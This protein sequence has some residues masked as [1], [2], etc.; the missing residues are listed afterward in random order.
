MSAVV[1]SSLETFLTALQSGDSD[2]VIQ[3]WLEQL[4]GNNNPP[5]LEWDLIQS[6]EPTWL[7]E[8][9]LIPIAY[10]HNHVIMAHPQANSDLQVHLSNLLQQPLVLYACSE[11]SL[12]KFWYYLHTADQSAS[13][14]SN[15]KPSEI[16]VSEIFKQL[17]FRAKQYRASDIHL[18]PQS[19]HSVLVR[20][21]IDGL[22]H[23]VETLQAT[24]FDFNTRLVSKIKVAADLDIA[25]TRI[26]QDGRITEIIADEP[27]DLR[28]ST[29]P[30][31]H[32]EKVVIRL[33]PHKN[34][35]QELRDLGLEGQ[36]L[37]T[38]YNWIKKPQGMVLITG[39]TGS[40]KTSTLYTTLSHILNA[41][42]N[43]VTIEDP[44]EYQL[45][46]A[47][48]VQVH[49]KV[50]LTFANGLRSIL[51]QDPDTILLGEIRDAE[52]AEIAYQAALTGHLV[53]STLHT[54][55]APSAIIRLMDIQVEPYLIASATLGVV[56][57]RLIR[58]VCKHCAQPY[59]PGQDLLRS[60]NLNPR[61]EYEFYH[62]M[63]CEAC[64]Q[65]GYYGREGIFEVMPVDEALANLI[66]Q[67][68]QLGKLRHHLQAQKVQSLY[69][70]AIGKVGRGLSTVEEIHRVVP[71]AQQS[72]KPAQPGS[73]LVYILFLISIL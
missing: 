42:K 15:E 37:L 32:G 26:P 4:E 64:F 12:R 68:E 66:T 35:F 2:T 38:Y 65:T 53:L 8:N 50:G 59:T 29:L 44:I 73:V 45:K 52:T 48:Q 72:Q 33:L 5:P 6:F 46:G 41:E 62:A 18:E 19:D 69:E 55:D 67:K 51:R 34:P 70:S 20:Y 39:Q 56:A 3:N 54:N 43:V 22:L 49:P 16:S 10:A 9:Q 21:R 24:E 31:L 61:Q 25:E 11:Q 13:P 28:V 58:R 40:G 23:D 17:L 71:P 27:V 47:T 1:F 30:S 63:G 36:A 7:A 57:Q 60:L 14:V